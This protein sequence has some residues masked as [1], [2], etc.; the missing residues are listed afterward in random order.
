MHG[1]NGRN[2]PTLGDACRADDQVL[3]LFRFANS[4][5]FGE[6]L[7]NAQQQVCADIEDFIQTSLTEGQGKE[8]HTFIRTC[9]ATLLAGN[10]WRSR[11][12][13]EYYLS[14]AQGEP[15]SRMPR[16]VVNLFKHRALET[17]SAAK[18]RLRRCPRKGCPKI[19][20]RTGKQEYCSPRCAG[21]A[22]LWKHRDK[23]KRMR[24]KAV[25]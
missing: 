8:C 13:V 22:R 3:W 2:A 17:I 7:S 25:Q 14:P 20:L 11:I 15:L 6:L 5:P 10:P 9:I 23:K 12:E 16:D 21:K 1:R 24:D 19:F 18:D 4:P